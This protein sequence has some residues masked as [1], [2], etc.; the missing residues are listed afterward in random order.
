MKTIAKL[1]PRPV[2]VIDLTNVHRL[3]TSVVEWMGRQ[4]REVASQSWPAPLLLAGVKQHSGVH[5]D[6]ERGGIDC[7]WLHH[8]HS[9]SSQ[10][11]EKD[12]ELSQIY[13]FDTLRD[14]LEW[15]KCRNRGK[16]SPEQM[17]RLQGQKEEVDITGSDSAS[18]ESILYTFCNLLAPDLQDILFSHLPNPNLSILERL[19]GLGIC[20]QKIAY[21][22]TVADKGEH[23]GR[24]DP[25]HFG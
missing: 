20:L 5:A 10:A 21:G 13:T 9:D 12:G 14:G 18:D 17:M 24:L 6:L 1:E 4:A 23:L 15:I 22:A 16:F 25:C 3:E 11:S 7:H 8:A 2:V 19:Q